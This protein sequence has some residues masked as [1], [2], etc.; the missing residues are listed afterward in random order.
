M[1][2]ALVAG[3]V[4]LCVFGCASSPAAPEVVER[5]APP[6]YEEIV[7][8]YNRTVEP[9][10]TLWSRATVQIMSPDGDGGT[11]REQGEGYLQVE[12]PSRAALSIGKLGETYFYLGSDPDRFWWIDLTDERIAIVG[13]H[14]RAGAAALAQLGVPVPPLDLIEVLGVLPLPAAPG[15]GQTAWTTDGR[16]VV[17]RLPGRLGPRLLMM[18]PETLRLLRVDLLDRDETL[19]VS[20]ELTGMQDVRVTGR[21]PGAARL[22]RR[23]VIT[24][25]REEVT[26]RL[27][28]Y[29]PQTRTIAPAVFDLPGLLKRFRV[30]TILEPRRE[31]QP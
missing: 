29:E 28:L 20:A 30:D 15:S 13:Q 22:P 4:G 7:Q 25:P 10:D 14:D 2:R 31:A 9:L 27:T 26:V 21:G 18:D 11:R 16:F 6:S 3:A 5:D 17:V 1:L 23:Y 12:R 24:I 19:L 8:R